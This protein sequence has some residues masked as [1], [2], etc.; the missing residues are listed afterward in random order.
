MPI[1]LMV[2][3]NDMADRTERA[4]PEI[5]RLCSSLRHSVLNLLTL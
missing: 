4:I 1:I 3:R 5:S 2:V